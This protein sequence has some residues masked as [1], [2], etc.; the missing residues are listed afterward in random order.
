MRERNKRAREIFR[1][2]HDWHN[3]IDKYRF[4]EDIPAELKRAWTARKEA[5]LKD[6]EGQNEPTKDP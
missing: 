1:L 2:L 3:M 6:L 5:L 4:V